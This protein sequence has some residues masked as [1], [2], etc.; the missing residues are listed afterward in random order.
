MTKSSL[1]SST[2]TKTSPLFA[3]RANQNQ[4]RDSEEIINI[5]HYLEDKLYFCFLTCS[6]NKM[7]SSEEA[8]LIETP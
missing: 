1:F 5:I 6:N 8:I 7:I 2:P 3:T 4:N